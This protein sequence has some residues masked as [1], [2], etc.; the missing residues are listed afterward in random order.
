[1]RRLRRPV[2]G[3]SRPVGPPDDLAAGLVV[4]LAYPERLARARQPGA[5]SYLMAGGTAAE[6][7]PG[8]ELAGTAWLAIAVADRAPGQPSARI[9]LAAA[10][11]EAT[12]REVGAPLVATEDEVGWSGTE[13]V[14]RR[15]ERLGALVLAEHR[16]RSPDR[17]LVQTA[18][19]DAVRTEGLTALGWSAGARQLRDRLAFCHHVLGEP[20][21]DVSDEAL[22]ARAP[23]WLGPELAR[24]RGR[25][26]LRRTDLVAALRR[27][28]PWQQA[29][30]LDQIAPQHVQL[31]S[32][33]RARVDYTDPHLPVLALRVQEA[34]GWRTAP[35]VADGRVPVVLH[36]LSPAGRPVA[37]TS[38]LAS[39]W[40]TG[41]PQVR[42]ELRGRYPRHPWPQDP[43]VAPPARP[44]RRHPQPGS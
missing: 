34:F 44:A 43:T 14:A 40:R 25:D 3:G 30:R 29:A 23:E 41:Y 19:L 36:L 22:L 5:T 27:L 39:F 32:G 12:A 10:I 18:L 26:D 8:S 17:A 15:V 9:R 35:T 16:L 24:A 11:D 31:P 13:L 6:L 42:A 33:S 2:A 7:A 1:V 38:D 20:W 4:G 28:L 37:V 21:P